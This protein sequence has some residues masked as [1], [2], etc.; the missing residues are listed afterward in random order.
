MSRWISC[1]DIVRLNEIAALE[2]QLI[3]ILFSKKTNG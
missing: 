2:G 3:T 1:V